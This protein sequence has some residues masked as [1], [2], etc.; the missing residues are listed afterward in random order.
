MDNQFILFLITHAIAAGIGALIT[1]EYL[2][3]E[4]KIR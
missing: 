3:G 2:L 4:G 1:Y